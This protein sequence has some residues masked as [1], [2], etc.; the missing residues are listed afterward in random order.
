M[1]TL[2]ST[3]P[4]CSHP[5]A[6]PNIPSPV[7]AGTSSPVVHTDSLSVSPRGSRRRSI[8]DRLTRSLPERN[9]QNLSDVVELVKS[10]L[11]P[12]S[13]IA[14]T[15]DGFL[16]CLLSTYCTEGLIGLSVR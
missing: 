3:S 6:L 1:R 8:T 15:Y 10:Q 5:D 12:H 4:Q 2:P 14:I 13:M 7:E 11:A 9:V 16:D